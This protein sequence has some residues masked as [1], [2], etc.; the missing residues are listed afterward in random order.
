MAVSRADV[1]RIAELARLRLTQDEVARLTVELNDILAHVEALKE[2]DV[3]DVPAM[4]LA[5]EWEAPTRDDVPGVDP[6]GLSIEE[7]APAVVDGFF[8]VPR[9]AALG[10]Q[11][12]TMPDAGAGGVA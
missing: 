10:G 2:V 11:D 8:T 12:E 4:G 3:G 1:L 9:L 5:A 7:M 6:L